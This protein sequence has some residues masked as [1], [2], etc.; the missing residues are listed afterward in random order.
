MRLAGLSVS[1][2]GGSWQNR[3]YELAAFGLARSVLTTDAVQGI[4]VRRSVA[5]GEATLPRSDIDLAIVLNP[6]PA[7]ENEALS[8][9]ALRTR[10]RA[11]RCLFPRLGEAL[12]HT[13]EELIAASAGDPYRASIDRRCRL[14]V[15]GHP[16]AIPQVPIRS[17]DAARRLVFWFD[18]YIP[19][20][21]RARDHRNLRKFALEIW[22]AW[23][24]LSGAFAEP[25][26]TRA[27]SREDWCSSEHASMLAEAERSPEAA[28]GVCLQLAEW[29]HALVL[30]ALPR[31]NRAA[32]LEPAAIP[33]GM[34]PRVEIL[35]S[36]G[37]LPS[38]EALARGTYA[39]TA[40]VLDLLI[41]FQHPLWW[42]G[43]GSQAV[44]LGLASPRVDEWLRACLRFTGGERLR[45]PGFSESSVGAHAERLALV[46]AVVASIAAG[47][48]PGEGGLAFPDLPPT[49]GLS[50]EHYYRERFA[51]LSR[52]A[53]SLRH[54][55]QAL[56]GEAGSQHARSE[57]SALAE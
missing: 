8:M 43:L 38:R 57:S 5:S 44:E 7:V 25:L 34:P 31:P 35:P 36:A 2:R 27:A 4:Y 16:T 47:R 13:P 24:V 46:D 17:H 50:V 22:N 12:V 37:A 6:S 49:R 11:G 51:T 28:F 54:R 10:Y 18:R 23:R 15:S 33:G 26:L 1:P 3:V 19:D 55:I 21:I 29:A 52:H 40:E 53:A 45:A 30:P 41:H 56:Y 14:V 9:L 32:T 48:P 42:L 20:A 39:F